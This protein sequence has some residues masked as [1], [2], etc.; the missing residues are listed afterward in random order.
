MPKLM[1]NPKRL[2]L[3]GFASLAVAAPTHAQ[4]VHATAPLPSF[5]VATIKPRDPKVMIMITP[6]G[7]QNIV[8]VA[9]PARQLIVMAYNLPTASQQR[10]LGGPDWIGDNSNSYVIEGKVPTT[11][12]PAC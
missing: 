4:I 11:S 8:R 7:S 12:T 9:G 3:A 5:E 6:P 2:F 10:I 1:L